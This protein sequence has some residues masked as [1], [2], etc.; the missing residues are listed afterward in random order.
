LGYGYERDDKEATKYF[1][2][3]GE[4]KYKEKLLLPSDMN[5]VG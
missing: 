3:S 1:D 4:E 2:A 5:F